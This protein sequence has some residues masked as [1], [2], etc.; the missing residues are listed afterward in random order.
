MKC[1]PKLIE[2]DKRQKKMLSIFDIVYSLYFFI[3]CDG[4]FSKLLEL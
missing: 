2:S 1:N 3:N 4:K